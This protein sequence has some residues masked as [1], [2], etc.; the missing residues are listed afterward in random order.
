ML[1]RVGVNLTEKSRSAG[2][3][4]GQSVAASRRRRSETVVVG[5]VRRVLGV[6]RVLRAGGAGRR[7]PFWDGRNGALRG[8]TSGVTRV[9]GSGSSGGA[10]IR[11]EGIL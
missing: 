2:F 3:S 7:E 10:R 9:L 4:W 8:L 11:A 5:E 6:E 1:L